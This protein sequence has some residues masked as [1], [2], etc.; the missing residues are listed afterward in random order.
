M[1]AGVNG[2]CSAVSFAL[3]LNI[4]SEVKLRCASLAFVSTAGLE[5]LGKS[6]NGRYNIVALNEMKR[7]TLHLIDLCKDLSPD[8]ASSTSVCV[9]RLVM[10]DSSHDE[11]ARNH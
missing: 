1:R 10:S 2:N 11:M 6:L 3:L 8:L 9:Y 4:N 7:K 5:L